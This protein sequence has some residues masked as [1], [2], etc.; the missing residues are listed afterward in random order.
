M[1]NL[2][3]NKKYLLGC[4]YGPDSMALFSMLLN[5]GYTFSAA[6]VNY[7]LRVESDDEM[8]HLKDYCQKQGIKLFIR[9]LTSYNYKGNIEN[10]CRKIRYLFFK[11][12]CDK[13]GFDAT[14]VGHHQDDHIETYLMQNERK[15][16]VKFYGIQPETEIFGVKVIRPLLGYSKQELLN[17]CNQNNVPYSIDSSNLHNFYKRN[18]IRHS[19]VEKMSPEERKHLLDE[20][21]YKNFYL[22]TLFES[23]ER[24]DLYNRL[25]LLELDDTEFC[26]ALN[27]ISRLS[28]SKKH[29]LEIRKILEKEKQN[30]LIRLNQ[31]VSLLLYGDKVS[32]VLEKNINYS[33]S[34]N[35]PA[36]LDTE[37]FYLDFT[38]G[39]ENRNVRSNDY[40]LTIENAKSHDR[41][42]IKDYYV[43]ARR[44][45]IDW[46]MPLDL[47]KRW[48]VI[49]NKEGNIIYMPRYQ[50][51]FVPKS[52]D[53]F[54]VK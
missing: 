8:N 17:Y 20:I 12:L 2:D 31:G 32:V 6:L 27:Y 3:K 4:S 11:E 41:I 14:L 19:I 10:E 33:Y 18:R 5:E 48:P 40:P 23:F 50:K 16:L 25:S 7:H 30:R 29:C 52:T 47:R 9:D 22:L 13:Y 43:D 35:K 26:Y 38:N 45:F 37:Y 49:R 1:L 21:D 36:V 51:N 53:N 28:I 15:N 46:K 39:A 34:L 42:P 24:I 44:L 54:Y